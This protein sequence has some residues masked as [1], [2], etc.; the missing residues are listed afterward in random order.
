MSC[1]IGVGNRTSKTTT[2][3][4]SS[5]NVKSKNLVARRLR[6]DI[7]SQKE[8]RLRDRLKKT[9]VLREKQIAA[10]DFLAEQMSFDSMQGSDRNQSR[11]LSS[12]VSQITEVFE[13]SA[14]GLMWVNANSM[15]ELY[16]VLPSDKESRL[17]QELD[18]LRSTGALVRV[19][20]NNKPALKESST[21]G[22]W[23]VY[24][25]IRTD[26]HV[27]GLLIGILPDQNMIDGVLLK[28]FEV[29]LRN[30]AHELDHFTGENR[31]LADRL[32]RLE[33]D[34]VALAAPRMKFVSDR[35]RLTSLPIRASFVADLDI[36]CASEPVKPFAV[37]SFDFEEF[38]RVNSSFGYAVGDQILLD[39]SNRL[40]GKLSDEQYLGQLGVTT[41]GVHLAR[42][43]EDEFGLIV[44]LAHGY[45]EE[46]VLKFVQGLVL[47]IDRV[48][49]NDGKGIDIGSNAG[50]SCF[51][52]RAKTSGELLTQAMH[53][54]MSVRQQTANKV[55][56]YQ[57][58]MGE[59]LTINN[60]LRERELSLG[61]KD[62]QIRVWYQPKMNLESGEIIGAE[63]LVRWQHPEKGLLL[64]NQFLPLAESSGLVSEL[65]ECVL[66]DACE[67]IAQADD[68]GF[69]D[70]TVAINLSPIQLMSDGFVDSFKAILST[71]QA[72]AERFE[73]ELTELSIAR[74]IK[75]VAA[76][77]TE[78]ADIG[79]SI[80]LDDFGKGNASLAILRNLPV[81][82]L[83]IDQT[84]IQGLEKDNINRAIVN[85]LVSM[86]QDM[87][88]K[89]IAEGVESQQ[90][91]ES[92]RKLGCDEVQGYYVAKP[93]GLRS[94]EELMREW[95]SGILTQTD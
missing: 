48:Y 66:R 63:A 9:A 80:T 53:A 70:F 7:V 35:D 47:E 2:N 4:T 94:F 78:L 22:D 67:L 46:D 14:C 61:L 24:N 91:L 31:R 32:Y 52:E 49:I 77:L 86:G 55:A 20:Q 68:A 93:S 87:N 16:E 29:I 41:E 73:L 95:K 57:A 82:L 84:F 30:T 8:S 23:L 51:P 28:L 26:D 83:K 13:F 88:V 74:D 90:Q 17:T 64:P 19:L 15:L 71:H 79:F 56:C 43:G 60:L 10:L 12:L 5:S 6:Q 27:L 76:I 11:I 3:M 33:H 40:Q 59:S 50:F 36:L 44:E 1:E 42:I 45:L 54:R 58:A 37:I 85:A 39:A 69:S 89:V 75:P 25:A 72:S 21:H 65:G 38:S 34:N 92:V 81:K 18:Y 62:E